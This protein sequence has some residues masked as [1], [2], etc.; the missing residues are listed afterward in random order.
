[1]ADEEEQYTGASPEQVLFHAIQAGNLDLLQEVLQ[2]GKASAGK[3]PNLEAKNALG[4]TPVLASLRSDQLDILSALL[5]EEVDVDEGNAGR[6]GDRPLHL[7]VRIDD[8]EQRE[9]AVSQLLEAGS[10][11]KL[12][13]SD[14]F[15][16]ID[17]LSAGPQNDATR[18]LLRDAE[19]KAQFSQAD[20]VDEDDDE[21]DGGPP[22]DED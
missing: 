3:K 7:A 16:P 20:I 15:K 4:D 9:W 14:R 5:E 8:D 13:N 18:K 21:S 1:M 12:T 17:I 11:P 19:A 6:E 22:S 2:G 10:D